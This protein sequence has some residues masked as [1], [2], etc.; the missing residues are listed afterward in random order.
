MHDIAKAALIVDHALEPIEIAASA[1]LDQ[2]PPQIDELARSRW[3]RLAGETFAH[4]HRQSV[5]DWPLGAS[6]RCTAGSWQ[7]SHSAIASAWPRTIAASRSLSRRGGSGKRALPPTSPGRS[8]AKLT[9]RSPLPAIALRQIP[10]ARLNGSVG[11]S[12]VAPFGLMLD[13]MAFC[14]FADAERRFQL[15]ATFTALSGNSCPK[16]R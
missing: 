4:H 1:L 9:S 13:D 16:Q 14:L 6:L 12:L 15:N 10:T 7:A 11:A 5:L 2:R 3:R 8:E